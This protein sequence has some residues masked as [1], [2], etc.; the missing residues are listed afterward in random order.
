[1]EEKHNVFE[2]LKAMKKIE[3]YHS[4]KFPI[5]PEIYNSLFDPERTEKMM[6][7]LTLLLKNKKSF[8]KRLKNFFKKIRSRGRSI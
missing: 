8:K 3:T 6:K 7:L 2:D 5:S 4:G 1:M